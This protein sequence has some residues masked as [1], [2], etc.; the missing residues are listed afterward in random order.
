MRTLSRKAQ[1]EREV[2]WNR[3]LAALLGA[4]VF[5]TIGFLIGTHL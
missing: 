2:M 1:L 5:T 4:I 3:I